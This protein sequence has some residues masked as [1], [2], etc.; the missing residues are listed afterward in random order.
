MPDRWNLAGFH[1]RLIE[2]VGREQPPPWLVDRVVDWLPTLELDPYQYAAP[3]PG[4]GGELRIVT[5]PDAVDGGLTVVCSYRICDDD[6]VRC[7]RIDWRD[8]PPQFGH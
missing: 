5:V 6:V 7:D 1:E 4:G 3:E 8:D 2:W